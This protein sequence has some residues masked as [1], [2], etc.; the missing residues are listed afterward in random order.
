MTKEET[1]AVHTLKVDPEFA[2][3]IYDHTEDEVE[4]LEENIKR[5]GCRVPLMVWGET[6]VDGHN[7]YDICHRNN[8]PFAIERIDFED[9]DAAK[10]WIINDQLARRNL[11]PY[12]RSALVL[13]EKKIL[14]REAKER[15]REAGKQHG[16]GQKVRQNSDTP[17]QRTDEQLAEKAGVSRDTI[18]KVEKIEREADE[19]TKRKA[20]SGEMSVNK[21]YRQTV[22]EKTSAEALEDAAEAL[23]DAFN[24]EVER[25]RESR[26]GEPLE[27][28]RIKKAGVMSYVVE[29]SDGDANTVSRA[30]LLKDH[31]YKKCQHCSGYGIVRP[32]H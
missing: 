24:A 26:R 28:V 4:R 15:Q 3:L 14:E 27:L 23:E 25:A 5:E 10:A 29:W 9:K 20:Q 8:I 16:R 11:A 6:I 22:G 7:R 19:E 21:A 30:H 18:R 12:Q 31:G 2:N 13:K 32:D 1:K 17:I